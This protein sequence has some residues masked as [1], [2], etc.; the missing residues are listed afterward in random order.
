MGRDQFV[1]VKKS[2]LEQGRGKANGRIGGNLA[3]FVLGSLVFFNLKQQLGVGESLK[4]TFDHAEYYELMLMR[5]MLE[6]TMTT[7]MMLM[8]TSGLTPFFGLSLSFS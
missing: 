7:M 6:M 4:E 5:I 3:H 8:M 2:Q 1:C